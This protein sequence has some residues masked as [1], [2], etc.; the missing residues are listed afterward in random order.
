MMTP[1]LLRLVCVGILRTVNG[2]SCDLSPSNTHPSYRGEGRS[3]QGPRR[4]DDEADRQHSR[5]DRH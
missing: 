3:D 5:Q 2:C 1:R 4:A